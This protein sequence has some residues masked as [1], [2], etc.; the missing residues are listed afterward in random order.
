MGCHML[1][2]CNYT[3]IALLTEMRIESQCEPAQNKAVATVNSL[4]HTILSNYGLH[5]C[6]CSPSKVSPRYQGA[7]DA[8][9]RYLF[10]PREMLWGRP[11]YNDLSEALVQ[12]HANC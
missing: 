2:D 7:G 6:W 1:V 5:V 11:L 4:V 12:K 8:S 3:I 9:W 10:C